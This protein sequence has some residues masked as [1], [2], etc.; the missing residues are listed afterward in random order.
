VREAVREVL[1]TEPS[2]TVDYVSVADPDSLGE[3]GAVAG[4]AL[5]SLAARIDG[6]RLIDNERVV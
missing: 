1:A 5:L 4:R 6:V 2:V 3:L